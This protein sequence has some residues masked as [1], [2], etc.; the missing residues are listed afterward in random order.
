MAFVGMIKVRTAVHKSVANDLAADLQALGCC[1]F[2]AFS[3]DRQSEGSITL[4]L[5][6]RQRH[7]ESLLSDAR[8]VVRL[9]EPMEQNKESALARMLGDVPEISFDD[10]A[11][12]ADEANFSSFV[13]A[14]RQK[15]KKLSELRAEISRCKAFIVQT[16][17]LKSI[18]YPM[19]LFTKGTDNI[20]GMVVS[21]AKPASSQFDRL[22]SEVLEGFYE[23]QEL[24]GSPKDASVIFAVLYRREDHDQVLKAC[25]ELSANRVE[26]PKDFELTADKENERFLAEIAVLEQFE[27]EICSELV[28]VADKGL[29]MARYGRDYWAI[30]KSRLDS[31]IKA[32]STEDVI[33]W[34]LWLPEEMLEKVK[35]TVGVYDSLTDLVVVESDEGEY[36]PTLLRN[37]GWASCMEPL[38]LMYGTPTYGA[39]DPS[40]VMAPFFFVILGMCFGDAG[41]GLLLSGIFGY[42]LIKHKLTPTLRKFFVVLTAGMLC[43]VAFG[44]VSGSFFGDSID[45]FPFLSVLLPLKNKLQLLDPLN[46]PMT[47]LVISLCIGFVQ[48]MVGLV[49]AFRINW[50]QGSRVAALA[51]NGGW[52]F[53]LIAIVM[54]GLG[55]AGMLPGVPVRLAKY[56]SIA[57]ALL[58]VATQG[59]EKN[60]II[61]KIIS[62]VLSLYNVTGYMGDVL[63][64]SRILALGL[65]SAAVGMVLNLLAVLLTDVPYVGVV[66]AVLVFALGH[67]FSIAVNLLGAFIHTLRLQYVEF[68]GKFYDANGRDFSPL[69]RE[70]RYARL[71]NRPNAN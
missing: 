64:Y 23:L 35:Q 44:F 34:S 51:D 8:F 42:F 47:L 28:S 50:S 14:L 30:A 24:A 48:I 6:A 69:T 33:F 39:C 10:L 40:T 3:E 43:T 20:A 9:L 7:T 19:E 59:R 17:H 38:T 22:L 46:D 70:T 4:D 25:N 41:Y 11:A 56:A 65:G 60:G 55:A 58:L 21:I 49:L 66:L 1:E 68:F 54:Y 57:G 63:S 27:A 32:V 5:S 45:A 53:F 67:F 31:M 15:D 16:E 13:N 2:A 71:I 61:G 29:A 37:P 12:K 36:P 26:V 52:M 18:K 62:G